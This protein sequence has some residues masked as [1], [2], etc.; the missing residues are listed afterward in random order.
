M[1]RTTVVTGGGTGIGKAV[2]ARFAADGDQV[3][4]IGRRA[5]VLEKAAAEI[6][7][8]ALP[9]D[10]SEPAEAERVRA[11]LAGRFGGIDV[12]VNNAGGNVE[13][14]GTHEGVVDRWSGNFRANVLTAVLPTEALRDLLNPSGRVVFVSS[15]AALRGSGGSSY[16]PMKAALHPYAFDLAAALGPRGITVNVVAP[17]LIE[18]TEFFGGTLSDERRATL[19]AQTH[20]GRAGSPQD[21]AETVHWLASP[22][23]GHITAQIIQVSGGAE[24]GR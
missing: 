6:G 20:T 15:I 2:A 5:D 7:G 14:T 1:T 8:T 19:V 11:D 10:L 3:V 17:G 21:V 22:G 9:A 23:A 24:R 18:D 13:R 12:L 4:L 16:G